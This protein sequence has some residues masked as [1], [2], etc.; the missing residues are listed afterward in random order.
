MIVCHT[1]DDFYK[2]NNQDVKRIVTWKTGLYSGSEYEDIIQD[3]YY[4]LAY[5]RSVERFNA[6]GNPEEEKKMFEAYIV[7]CFGNFISSRKRKQD[8]AF[9]NRKILLKKDEEGKDVFFTNKKITDIKSND[10][11]TKN[12]FELIDCSGSVL[13]SI[14]NVKEE[15][16]FDSFRTNEELGVKSLLDGF[17][18]FIKKTND[19]PNKKRRMLKFIEFYE[20]GSHAHALAESEGI[21]NTYVKDI[22]KAMHQHAKKYLGETTVA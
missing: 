16:R 7:T 9:E 15:A 18:E 6:S 11:E 20:M 14:L 2:L 10:G 3:F 12:V 8:Q 4:N 21:S 5:H 22:K 1:L 17:K 13:G 19:K